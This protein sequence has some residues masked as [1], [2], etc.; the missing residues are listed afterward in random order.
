MFNSILKK[1]LADCRAEIQ[2]YQAKQV[3]F[4]RSTAIIEFKPNGTIIGAN[5]N[6]LNTV[7]YSLSELEGHHH[8]MFCEPDYAKSSEYAQ[9]W[10]RLAKGEFVRDRF[11]RVTKDKKKIW[12]EA[13][14]NPIKDDNGVVTHVIKLA[15]DITKQVNLQNEQKSIVSAID[16]AMA[17]VEFTPSG[18]VLAANTNFLNIMGYR[19]QDIQGKHHRMFCTH[20]DANSTEYTRFWDRLNRGEFASDIFKRNTQ[21]GDVRWLRATYNPVFDEKGKVVKIVEFATDVS[22]VILHQQSESQAAALAYDISVKTDQDAE[23]GSLIVQN[24]VEVVQGI[25]GELKAAAEGIAAVNV[26]SDRISN[27][28]QTIRGIA[29]QTNLLALNAAIEAARAGEQGRGFAVVADEVRSLAARTAQATVEIVDV[30]GQNQ[31]LAKSAVANMETSRAKVAQGVDLAS[32]AGNAIARIRQ[33]ATQVVEAI[34][35]FRSTV[36]N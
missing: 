4:D 9:F 13:S 19:L 1:E 25:A 12:L 22:D 14:Y 23:E 36:D 6:F 2:L 21:S 15:T 8:S 29:E 30:V 32:Q 26:Q 18:E 11:S 7:G 5:R 35:Q 16:R 10:S 17:M 3:G 27:I 33:G 31:E 20:D 28:V 24:T 34:R